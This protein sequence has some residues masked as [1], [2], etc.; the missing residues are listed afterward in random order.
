MSDSRKGGAPSRLTPRAVRIRNR[1]VAVLAQRRAIQVPNDAELTMMGNDI[2]VAELW[3]RWVRMHGGRG[4]KAQRRMSRML[5]AAATAAVTIGAFGA[6][7]L[8][9]D[10]WLPRAD[11]QPA[12]PAWMP[13]TDSVTAALDEKLLAV[14]ASDVSVT[15]PLSSAELAILILRPSIYRPGLSLDSIEAR[16]DTLLWIRGRLGDGSPF[17]VGG[18]VEVVRRGVAAFRIATLSLDGRA[19]DPR[20]ASRRLRYRAMQ[21]STTDRVWFEIPDRVGELRLTGGT[22]R[23]LPWSRD[24]ERIGPTARY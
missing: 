22:I 23:A 10:V 7:Y 18:S 24:A 21:R 1:C 16:V 8:A 13:I 5:A 4:G 19:D 3:S 11:A 15:I 14:A 9:R 6:A 17:I 12:A 20:F 2:G